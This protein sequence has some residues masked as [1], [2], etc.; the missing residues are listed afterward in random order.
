MSG[1][2][3]AWDSDG[4]PMGLRPRHFRPAIVAHWGC[5]RPF[6]AIPKAAAFPEGPLQV[7]H[8]SPR[9][10]STVLKLVRDK[11][12]GP[13]GYLRMTAW[14]LGEKLGGC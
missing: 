8:V 10:A 5:Q 13:A 7:L 11:S 2:L 14:P 9:A 12:M 3:I 1:N 4:P 6:D